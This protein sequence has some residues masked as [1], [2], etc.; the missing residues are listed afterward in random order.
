MS[1]E[2]RQRALQCFR[3]AADLNITIAFSAFAGTD[4][5]VDSPAARMRLQRDEMLEEAVDE[6]ILAAQEATPKS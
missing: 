2:N 5:G 4:H 3:L 1:A 6:M